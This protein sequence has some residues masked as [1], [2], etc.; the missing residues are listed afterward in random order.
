MSIWYFLGSDYCFCLVFVGVGCVV[1]VV[2]V[3]FGCCVCL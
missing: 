3:C 1:F 2:G